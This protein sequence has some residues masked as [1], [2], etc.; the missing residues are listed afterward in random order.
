MSLQPEKEVSKLLATPDAPELGPGPRASVLDESTL[1]RACEEA[2]ARDAVPKDSQELV[3]ALVL[4]WHDH[5]DAAH[6]IVQDLESS[7]GA[8]VHAIL[9]RREPDFSNAKYWFRRLGRHNAFPDIGHRVAALLRAR[10]QD[11][12][13]ELLTPNGEWQALEYVDLCSEASRPPSSPERKQLLREIQA[14]ESRSLL[15]WF[16]R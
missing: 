10:G 11:G 1:N 6:R 15:A 9:H 5:L 16:C 13:A 3:R 4:L 14:I 2:F 7:D 8:F 12:L